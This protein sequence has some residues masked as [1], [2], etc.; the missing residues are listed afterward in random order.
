MRDLL[1]LGKSKKGLSNMVGYVLL[2]TITISLSFFVYNWLKFYVTQEDFEKC[3]EGVNL[4][5]SSYECTKS[6]GD[7]SGN[8]NLTLKNK[9]LF[10]VNGYILRVHDREDAKFGFYIFDGEG[11][12]IEPG[13]T[14]NKN[15]LLSE[16]KVKNL[17]DLTLV[18]VQPY[19]R[20]GINVSCES[21]ALQRIN[22]D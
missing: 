5:I 17:T 12:T 7:V 20:E 16:Y 21:Y 19:I 14:I 10:S 22:C 4:I 9:G 2:I 18:E 15:Y 11:V 13:K 6:V 8:L 1:Q 3:P